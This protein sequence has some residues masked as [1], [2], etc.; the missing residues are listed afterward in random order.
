[1]NEIEIG[2][3]ID[4][5]IKA[6]WVDWEPTDIEAG[7]WNVFLGGLD[8]DKAVKSFAFWRTSRKKG[9]G[10]EPLI[11]FL[12]P[13]MERARLDHGTGGQE[14]VEVYRLR[15]PG[16]IGRPFMAKSM[17]SPPECLKQAEAMRDRYVGC[18]GGEWVIVRLWEE[19]IPDSGLRGREAEQAVF[20]K[21]L[22]G[23]DCK[24][25]RWVLH[26]L[27]RRARKESRAIEKRGGV[28]GNVTRVGEVIGLPTA[29]K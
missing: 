12:R 11:A 7:D 29:A 23:P 19:D 3:F 26:T 13:A 25:Q 6:L 27:D 21:I 28:L 22:A 20:D 24:E 5:H 15:R 1:M 16:G 2:T 17:P 10:R 9:K 18:Y 8:F 4:H 14:W